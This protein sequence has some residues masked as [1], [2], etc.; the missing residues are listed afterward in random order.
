ME[1]SELYRIGQINVYDESNLLALNSSLQPIWN[2]FH[3]K[4]APLMMS[5]ADIAAILIWM[6][7]NQ[8][9]A[10]SSQ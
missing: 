3:A 1:R 6:I 5:E 7:A 4:L 9:T 2:K 10:L 8:V